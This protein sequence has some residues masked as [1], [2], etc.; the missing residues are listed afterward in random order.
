MAAVYILYSSSAKKY[1]VGA[2]DRA[3]ESRFQ[4]HLDAIFPQ[5]FTKRA[6]DWELVLE[7]P[8]TSFKQAICIENK[9]KKQKSRIYIENLVKFPEM[10]ERLM[11]LCSTKT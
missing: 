5:A 2:T 9:I 10:R 6:K 11:L 1:Y 8:C 7:L 4:E 3:V